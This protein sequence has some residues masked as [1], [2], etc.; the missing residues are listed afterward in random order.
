MACFCRELLLVYRT[1]YLPRSKT[2]LFRN[3]TDL[4]GKVG[5]ESKYALSDVS[6][7]V[8]GSMVVTMLPL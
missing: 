7:T 8:S 5:A 2:D 1:F 6:V 3:V 4:E